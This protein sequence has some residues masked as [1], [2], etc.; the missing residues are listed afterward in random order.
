MPRKEE[1]FLE[2]PGFWVALREGLKMLER[3]I[4]FL[5]FRERKLLGSAGRC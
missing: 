2:N 5:S 4:L 3:K 1:E